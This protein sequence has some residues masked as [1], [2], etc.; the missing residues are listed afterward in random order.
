VRIPRGLV[1]WIPTGS[2]ET[3][4]STQSLNDVHMHAGWLHGPDIKVPLTDSPTPYLK[5]L[6]HLQYLALGSA[7]F[8]TDGVE[9]LKRALPDTTVVGPDER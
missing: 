1:M 6:T 7:N 8:S 4:W 9:E 5:K 3:E 2:N